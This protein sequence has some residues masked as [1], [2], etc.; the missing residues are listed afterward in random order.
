MHVSWRHAWSSR[1]AIKAILAVVVFTVI[2]A[3]LSTDT[4]TSNLSIISQAAKMST[5]RQAPP[6]HSP[7]E[8]PRTANRT[9]GFERVMAI[10]LPERSDK[11]DALDL[12]ASLTGFDIDWED[13]V[14]AS[15]IAEKAVP[16]GIGLDR[17]KDNFLGSWRGH[18][19]A[20]RR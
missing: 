20:I 1:V 12:M 11:R 5:T 10:S 6:Q 3:Y 4:L 8:L 16:H 19:N 2:V 9:L 14:K 18:M 13:G 7:A 15:S 17:A